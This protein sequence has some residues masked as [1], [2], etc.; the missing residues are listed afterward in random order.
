M[1]A[2]QSGGSPAVLTASTNQHRCIFSLERKKLVL[3]MTPFSRPGCADVCLQQNQMSTNQRSKQSIHPNG[4]H[5]F[6]YVKGTTILASSLE[7]SHSWTEKRT[8]HHQ[9]VN[10][11]E[12]EKNSTF[13]VLADCTESLS[14]MAGMTARSNMCSD[15]IFATKIRCCFSRWFA[16][17]CC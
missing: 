5:R 10:Q 2:T 17:I 9:K 15:S 1:G 14:G 12:R 13:F 16:D 11:L 8:C 3:K 6:S 4:L 7:R